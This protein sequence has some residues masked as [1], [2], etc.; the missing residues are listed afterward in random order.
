MAT[1][2]GTTSIGFIGLGHMGGNMAA[3]FLAAGHTVYGE[4]RS[5]DDAQHLVDAGLHWRDTVTP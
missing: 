2:E 1:S 5:R 4:E 3:R